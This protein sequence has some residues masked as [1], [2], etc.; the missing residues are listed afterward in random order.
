MPQE[1]NS[2]IDESML[3]GESFA[4]QKASG[5]ALYGGTLNQTGSFTYKV[6]RVGQDTVLGEIIRIVEE[7]QGSKAPIQRLVD[8]SLIHI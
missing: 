1:M 7:A 5:S 3:T 6:T 2:W 8:L 4:V